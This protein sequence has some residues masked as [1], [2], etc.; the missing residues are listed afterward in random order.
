MS[1]KPQK[2][3]IDGEIEVDAT[4]TEKHTKK[5]TVTKYPVEEGIQPTDH[6]REEPLM[7]MIEGIFTDTP[8]G[9]Q[10]QASLGIEPPRGTFRVGGPKAPAFPD[11]TDDG[12]GSPREGSHSKRSLDSLLGI[13]ASRRAVEISGPIQTYKNMVLT[14]LEYS[15]DAK[16]G[17]AIRFTATFEEVRFAVRN[18]ALALPTEPKPDAK[19]TTHH[20]ADQGKKPATAVPPEQAKT[21]AKQ[22]TDIL[23]DIFG[24][25]KSGQG[26]LR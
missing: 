11:V 10:D 2:V 12:P 22:I 7:L 14:S 8:V 9:Q 13:A 24:F 23:T 3:L 21:L 6:A 1:S 15:R 25:T 20:K 5:V 19:D 16:T 18:S 4:L 17:D 26:V